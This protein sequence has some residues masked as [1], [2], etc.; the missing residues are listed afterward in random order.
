MVSMC[1]LAAT[2]M[3]VRISPI[4]ACL[5]TVIIT[6]I[7]LFS[8]E[9]PYPAHSIALAQ[10]P[11][12]PVT[13]PSPYPEP[14]DNTPVP[15]TDTPVPPTNTPIPPTDTPVPPT[16]TPIPPTN[17]PI[18]PTNTPIP[19]TNTAT[20]PPTTTP[21]I[22]T[23]TTPT[24]T[25]TSTPPVCNPDQDL[26]GQITSKGLFEVVNTSLFCD[27]RVGVATYRLPD[28]D[29]RL[30]EKNDVDYYAATTATIKRAAQTNRPATLQLEVGYPSCA[31][32]AQHGFWG[33]VLEV[34]GEESYGER[35][36]AQQQFVPESC[37]SSD[38]TEDELEQPFRRER[39]A[40]PPQNSTPLQPEQSPDR[41][42]SLNVDADGSMSVENAQ[43]DE[44]IQELTPAQ[45]QQH[46]TIDITPNTLPLTGETDEQQKEGWLFCLSLVL[47]IGGIVFRRWKIVY[48]AQEHA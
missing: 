16:D 3:K 26:S 17:T 11:P 40:N 36:L 13:G 15:P 30:D 37:D 22:R 33:N 42:S 4:Y 7:T 38:D 47:I 18:P 31:T 44:V 1:G 34:L 32:F 21:T 23:T 28:D 39:A 46:N 41:P 48:N 27:Y 19:P 25:P 24:N 2:G 35:G 14:P 45:S 10:Y 8:V 5:I 20:M 12:P 43:R 29:L 9:I 6:L